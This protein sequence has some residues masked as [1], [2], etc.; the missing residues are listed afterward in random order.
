M[1]PVPEVSD[2]EAGDGGGAERPSRGRTPETEQ[3]RELAEVVAGARNGERL[4]RSV[5]AALHQLDLAVLDDV[6]AVAGIALV[7]QELARGELHGLG[8]ERVPRGARRE[9]DDLIRERDH[10]LVVR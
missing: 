3:R 1:H 4:F 8:R 9:L 6:D 7:E 5:R 10:A 2:V